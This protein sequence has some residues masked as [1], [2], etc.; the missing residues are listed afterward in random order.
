MHY[1][2]DSET[3]SAIRLS[4]LLVVDNPSIAGYEQGEFG[5]RLHYGRSI[6][7]PLDAFRTARWTS[8]E[9][10]QRMTDAEWRLEGSN[11][12]NSC[13]AAECWLEIYSTY[14]HDYAAQ[15]VGARGSA[16]G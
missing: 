7:A 9:I 4:R 10:L 6:E 16:N 2:P 12:E 15:I 13:H 14:A 11:A 3:M 5:R 8:A 1:L